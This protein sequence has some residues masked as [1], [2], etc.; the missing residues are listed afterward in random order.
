MAKLKIP[1]LSDTH[2][3]Y[4]EIKPGHLEQTITLSIDNHSS[5]GNN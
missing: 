5:L 4:V 3:S 1:L 2:K